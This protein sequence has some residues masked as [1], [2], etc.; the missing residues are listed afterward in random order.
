MKTVLKG[1]SDF[2]FPPRCPCCGE[3]QPDDEPCDDC[4][5]ELNK[6]RVV[7]A[8]C[9][10][11]GNRVKNC[12]CAK[13]NNL[14]NGISGAFWNDGIAQDSVYKMKFCN[15]PDAAE[16]FGRQ[17]ALGFLRKFP[18]VKPDLIV[19]VPASKRSMAE[20]GYN[21]AW[22]LAKAVAKRLEIPVDSN[23]L[24]KFKENKKQHDLKSEERRANVKGVYKVT[25]RLDG[26][27]VLLVDDIKTTGLTLSECA[28]QLRLNGAEEVYTAVVL[29]TDK[30]TC[31]SDS[32][33]I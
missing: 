6:C 25:K 23:V 31:N 16:Y 20:R 27:T 33:E 10:K 4:R 3:V 26:K 24:I 30:F 15:R 12:D 32:I 7:T 11:C 18:D 22:L 14:F 17:T 8:T 21:Q 2:L 9:D 28:K 1:I 5:K 29:I 13:F 19:P